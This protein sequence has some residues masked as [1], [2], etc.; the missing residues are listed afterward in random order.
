MLMKVIKAVNEFMKTLDPKLQLLIKEDS[1]FFQE[2][3]GDAVLRKSVR[4]EN[5]WSIYLLSDVDI[6]YC[7]DML[8][9]DDKLNMFGIKGFIPPIRSTDTAMAIVYRFSCYDVMGK[10]MDTVTGFHVSILHK[11]GIQKDRK[12]FMY[13]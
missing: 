9:F 7:T 2:K 1:E 6:Y 10:V 8:K 4:L 13:G 12:V 3:V 5:S 11:N